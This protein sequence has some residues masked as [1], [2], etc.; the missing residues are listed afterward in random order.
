MIK[1]HIVVIALFIIGNVFSRDWVEV[2]S[3]FPSE[4][5][6]AVLSDAQETV[7]LSFELS[8]YFLEK[9][10]AGNK[11]NFPGGVSISFNSWYS[12]GCIPT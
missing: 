6:V 8:G 9:T 12:Y 2:N 7:K 11:I 5:T 4:P 1:K 10:D 3:S